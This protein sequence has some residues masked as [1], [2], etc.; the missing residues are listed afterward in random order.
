MVR[1]SSKSE[2]ANDGLRTASHELTLWPSKYSRNPSIECDRESTDQSSFNS[3]CNRGPLLPSSAAAAA[4]PTF[5]L[6]P[7]TSL[8]PTALIV[9][10]LLM[11]VS[12]F[13][14]LHAWQWQESTARQLAKVLNHQSDDLL[15]EGV[16]SSDVKLSKGGSASF[17]LDVRKVQLGEDEI[18]PKVTMLTRWEGTPPSS[19]GD[20]VRFRALAKSP[21]R[22]RNP[23]EFDYARWLERQE[24][25]TELRM[26]P[27]D[28]GEILSSGN[29]FR[30]MTWALESRRWLEHTLALG[31]ADDPSVVS[32]IKGMTLGITKDAPEGFTDDFK[33]TGTMH[34]FAV[35]GLHVGMVAVIVWFFLKL[36]RVPRRT[37]V[38]VTIPV[39]FFYAMMTGLR[40]GSLRAVIMASIVLI[41]FLFYRRPQMINSLAAAAFFL[42]ATQTNLLFSAGW[43]FS[44]SVVLAI[45]LL[46][47]PLQHWLERYD[48]SDPFLPKKFITPFQKTCHYGLHHLAQLLG[49]SIAAWIG[50]LI[51][52][53]VYFHL[54]SFSSLGA[55][56]VVVPLAFIILS[57]AALSL[58]SGLIST[59]VAIIFNNA[60]WLFTKLLLLVVHGFALLPVS[61]IPVGMPS[62]SYPVMTLFDL[63]SAQVGILQCGGKTWA[64]NTGRAIN[65]TKTVI[66]FLENAGISHLEGMVF[67][68]K[69]S[70]Q[71]GGAALLCSQYSPHSIMTS[72]GEGRSFLFRR[73]AKEL[74]MKKYHMRRLRVGDTITFASGCWGEVLYSPVAFG[75]EHKKYSTAEDILVLKIHLGKTT[76]LMIPKT[77]PSVLEWLLSHSIPDALQ[78]NILALD[79]TTLEKS[80]SLLSVVKPQAIIVSSDPFARYGMLHE[81]EKKELQ[82][83]GITV[84]SQNEC[85]AVIVEVRP[86]ETEVRGFFNKLLS[87]LY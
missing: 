29:G 40:T 23:G 38:V 15:V 87:K 19:Y 12:C 1:L 57:I 75:E 11:V 61:S 35:S 41:G 32:V 16:V 30:L 13:A 70:A 78:S 72:P 53:I 4:S 82:R 5:H 49:V 60:N 24:V 62:P 64:L 17:F 58:L 54:I 22:P 6:S 84:F 10:L 25:Y 86:H 44:F 50:S 47:S 39:L 83:A 18:F 3:D 81:E 69:D 63:S 42:L 51:P 8:R 43:Q 26:D 2:K 37:A 74:T 9:M 73:F 80:K 27:S 52:C 28:P 20:L 36:I 55:N 56:V 65:V 85:G 68:K 66:P 67:T 76:L 21:L 79:G 48:K 31:I 33:L 34:L 14:T 71:L 59:S 77:T 45:L 7:P 46:A